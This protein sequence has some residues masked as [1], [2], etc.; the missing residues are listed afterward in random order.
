[1]DVSIES[2]G[3]GYAVQ[4]ALSLAGEAEIAAPAHAREA[5]RDE[6]ARALRLP[7]EA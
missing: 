7:E 4:L 5:L 1:V 2:A 3:P 6:V